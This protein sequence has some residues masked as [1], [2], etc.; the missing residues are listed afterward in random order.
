VVEVVTFTSTL[1]YACE[2]R[3]TTARCGDVVDEF[4]HVYRL[5]YA[6]AAE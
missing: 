1:T 6:G 5:T 2:Y 4:H 3:Q